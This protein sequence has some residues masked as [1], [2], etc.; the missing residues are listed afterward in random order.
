MRDPKDIKMYR[1][2]RG[3]KY[4]CLV[5]IIDGEHIVIGKTVCPPDTPVEVKAKLVDDAE[6]AAKAMFEKE[7]KRWG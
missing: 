7:S 5:Q 6:R 4:S 2:T 1:Y 3:D